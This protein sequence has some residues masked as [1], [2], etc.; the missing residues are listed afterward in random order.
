[1]KGNWITVQPKS[2]FP[3]GTQ[4]G[5]YSSGGDS[6]T[7]GSSHGPQEQHI[8]QVCT[9]LGGNVLGGAYHD[10]RKNR[11]LD[12]GINY[13][14]KGIASELNYYGFNDPK[15]VVLS[16]CALED[17]DTYTLHQT[18]QYY[19]LNLTVLDLSNNCLGLNSVHTIF[20]SMRGSQQGDVN[21]LCKQIKS[22]NL[23]NNWLGDNSALFISQALEY[24]NMPNLKYLD[25]SGNQITAT[26][27]GYFVNS[28][29][30]LKTQDMVVILKKITETGNEAMQS[31]LNFTL[32]GLRYIFD[33][34]AKKLGQVEDAAIAIYGD[35][36]CKKGLAE[37]F[38]GISVGII[39]QSAK[40]PS[41]IKIADKIPG[42]KKV[43]GAGIAIMA[44][45]D[46]WEDVANVDMVRCIAVI[47]DVLGFGQRDIEEYTTSLSGDNHD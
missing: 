45:K 27:E 32:K 29:T 7:S 43:L 20:Y 25:V 11:D 18:L 10:G 12:D 19:P 37:A 39:K 38:Q 44:V 9:S 17:R 13:Q 8:Q 6:K 15:G 42:G 14:V 5:G 23:S 41:A 47:N 22:I 36:H 4:G 28:L 46:N 40:Y 3:R 31:A 34:H 30:S 16:D 33:Q 1:M 2:F 26:G 35:D 24:G 21:H